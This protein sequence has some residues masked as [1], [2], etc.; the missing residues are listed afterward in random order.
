MEHRID[1]RL[2]LRMTFSAV[3][4]LRYIASTVRTVVLSRLIDEL[5]GTLYM[6][7]S[8]VGSYSHPHAFTLQRNKLHQ[9]VLVVIT[10]TQKKLE[11][12]SAMQTRDIPRKLLTHPPAGTPEKTK[13]SQGRRH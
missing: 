4:T 3:L 12:Y 13:R 8:I 10:L 7:K 1:I 5:V 9:V 6:W 11:G 2:L